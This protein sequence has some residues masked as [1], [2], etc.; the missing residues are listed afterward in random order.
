[1][2]GGAGRGRG[3]QTRVRAARCGGAAPLLPSSPTP[4]ASPR[5]I[6]LR[7]SPPTHTPQPPSPPRPATPR[8]AATPN[9]AP[10]AGPGPGGR[11]RISPKSRISNTRATRQRGPI[12]KLSGR[13]HSSKGPMHHLLKLKPILIEDDASTLLRPN[14]TWR[15]W[16]LPNGVQQQGRKGR[17]DGVHTLAPPA[18]TKLRAEAEAMAGWDS[19]RERRGGA[20]KPRTATETAAVRG[21]AGG[22]RLAGAGGAKGRG[23]AGRPAGGGECRGA[24]SGLAAP[25][26]PGPEAELAARQ[27]AL[28]AIAEIAARRCT[29]RSGR[30]L[31]PAPP[32]QDAAWPV[33]VLSLALYCPGW[34]VGV[35][36]V[37]CVSCRVGQCIYYLRKLELA[38]SPFLY[39]INAYCGTQ[40]VLEKF[41][42]MKSGKPGILCIFVGGSYL[43]AA[44]VV[45]RFALLSKLLVDLGQ[46]NPPCKCM[47]VYIC[48][49]QTSTK[50]RRFAA[51]HRTGFKVSCRVRR[52]LRHHVMVEERTGHV[53][54]GRWEAAR[55]GVARGTATGAHCRLSRRICSRVSPARSLPVAAGACVLFVGEPHSSSRHARPNV[56]ANLRCYDCLSKSFADCADD[57][58]MEL[59]DKVDCQRD[60]NLCSVLIMRA[61]RPPRAH[62]ATLLFLAPRNCIAFAC[63]ISAVS[64]KPRR[65]QGH[66]NYAA[67]NF[68]IPLR[69]GV[70]PLASSRRPRRRL[71]ESLHSSRH[72]CLLRPLRIYSTTLPTYSNYASPF[73]NLSRFG[74]HLL[75]RVLLPLSSLCLTP[76]RPL[77]S[78][79]QGALP[80]RHA[81]PLSA[82][83][84]SATPLSATPLSATPLSAT[85]LSAT[86]RHAPHRSSYLPGVASF[87]M[88]MIYPSRRDCIEF[89]VLIASLHPPSQSVAEI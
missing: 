53:T 54:G 62:K 33:L 30:S 41:S 9:A 29:F 51:Q 40:V 85:P 7:A 34:L 55:R 71:R 63:V 49:M 24:P 18:A 73:T 77:C 89:L 83:P 17:G 68:C 3:G 60:E 58:K 16:D 50:A 72:L 59:F 28:A 44:C 86:P 52:P 66:F 47:Y 36:G 13:P 32:A 15:R 70:C 23:G 65:K 87:A 43:S 48:N 37:L 42:P 4:P 22:R 84:L 25:A 35:V 26:R 21:F 57:S 19:G 2:R 11:E 12:H 46:C 20:S 81:T 78:R 67:G 10:L 1:M 79:R 27:P 56:E 61:P 6:P 64:Q 38:S 88:E 5:A 31:S 69:A 74:P 39:N 80:P 14:K 82:T 76:P 8:P 75:I 45:I